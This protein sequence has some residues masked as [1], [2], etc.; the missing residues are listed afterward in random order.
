MSLRLD[1]QEPQEVFRIFD[2]L[3][4]RTDDPL[5]KMKRPSTNACRR[6]GHPRPT[7]C[8]LALPGL[9]LSEPPHLGDVDLDAS[10]PSECGEAGG[11]IYANHLN[12]EPV[13][14]RS[15]LY[16]GSGKYR[17]AVSDL[18]RAG[19]VRSCATS[20]TTHSGM[21]TLL[22]ELGHGVYAF[23]CDRTLPFML[24]DAAPHLHHP[25]AFADMFGRLT[26]TS[27]DPDRG[28]IPAEV[29]PLR[30]SSASTTGMGQLVLPLVPRDGR[31]LSD[32]CTKIRIRI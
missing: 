25:R 7:R 1:E 24:R 17:C 4:A 27:G 31:I 32:R 30:E 3:A 16:G 20:A 13:L 8:S 2:E 18:D 29:D 9:L 19:D 5:P 14:A 23:Y 26:T 10:C 12:V 11:G 6:G 28:R 22:H 21:K 15:D